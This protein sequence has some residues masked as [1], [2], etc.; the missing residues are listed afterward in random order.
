[1]LLSVELLA[2][3]CGFFF[4]RGTFIWKRTCSTIAG[5]NDQTGFARWKVDGRGRRGTAAERLREF[6]FSFRFN[7][8]RIQMAKAEANCLP[9]IDQ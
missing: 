7:H 2:F 6:R 1:M 3:R 5:L 8:Q 4:P 9:L